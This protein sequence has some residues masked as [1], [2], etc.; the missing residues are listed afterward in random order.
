MYANVHCI[1]ISNETLFYVSTKSFLK[2]IQRGQVA[3][4]IGERLTELGRWN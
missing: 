4:D 1:R 2:E 3:G